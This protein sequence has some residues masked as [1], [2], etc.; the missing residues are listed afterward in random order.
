M[1]GVQRCALPFLFRA[2]RP[3][4][5]VHDFSGRLRGDSRTEGTDLAAVEQGCVSITPVRL[6][7]TASLDDSVRRALERNG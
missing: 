7:H 3:G 1:T 5:Y 2:A 6:A 4:V